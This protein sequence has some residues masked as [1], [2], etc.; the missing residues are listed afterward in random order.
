MR[1]FSMNSIQQASVLT[2]CSRSI[3]KKELDGFIGQGYGI[4]AVNKVQWAKLR[5][6]AERARWVSLTPSPTKTLTA[7]QAVDF[8]LQLKHSQM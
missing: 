7:P 3:A 6:S 4:F 8:G 1:S 5:F 2:M